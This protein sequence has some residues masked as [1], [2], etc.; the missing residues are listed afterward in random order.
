MKYDTGEFYWG[1]SFHFSFSLHWTLLTIIS[2]EHLDVFLS[3]GVKS[4]IPAVQKHRPKQA[5]DPYTSRES[6]I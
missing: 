3:V 5:V 4:R 2:R 1:L 6:K